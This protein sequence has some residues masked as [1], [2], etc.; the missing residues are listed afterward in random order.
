M[1]R[2]GESRTQK[3]IS[4]PKIRHFHRKE[5]VFTVKGR[6]GP[7]SKET[8][9]PISF[10]LREVIR[11]A[12]NSKEC[13]K[14][15][16]E[17]SVKVNGNVRRKMEFPAGIFDLVEIVPLK[18]KYRL[19]LDTKGRLRASEVDYKSKDFKVSKVVG[20]RTVKSGKIMVTTNDGFNIELGKEKISVD[21][22]V[23]VS[24]P[25]IKIEEVYH[26]ARGSTA[27]VIAGIHVGKTLKV[28]GI[29]PGALHKEK[30][31]TLSENSKSFDT[32]L[33]NVVVVGKDKP[34]IEA[35]R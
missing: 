26:A 20:K 12:G 31:V 21:D 9:V 16:S 3:S 34:E 6:P 35:L 15:L 7:H 29:T 17:A 19:V 27:Y 2:K 11:V 33:R 5:T 24:L 13:K 28:E 32:V 22:S 23:K 14:I 18:K 8:S 10:L 4:A 25:E 30:S 1:A